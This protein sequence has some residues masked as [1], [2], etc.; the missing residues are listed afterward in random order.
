M[1]IPVG[2]FGAPHLSGPPTPELAVHLHRLK[3]CLYAMLGSCAAKLLLTTLLAG[4]LQAFLSCGNLIVNSLIGIMLLRDDATIKPMYE[5]LMAYCFRSCA[6][7][8][9]GSLTCLL[10]FVICNFITAIMEILG[11]PTLRFVCKTA[12]LVAEASTWND[13]SKLMELAYTLALAVALISQFCGA[14]FGY[15]AFKEATSSYFNDAS[16][17]GNPQPFSGPGRALQPSSGMSSNAPRSGYTPPAFRASPQPFQPFSGQG[18]TLGG[19]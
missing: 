17:E 18:Q 16:T 19:R 4:P 12:P 14:I 2:G 7:Q 15:Q 6:E 10:P 8:C 3:V 11:G 5:F 1:V 9:T 13:S